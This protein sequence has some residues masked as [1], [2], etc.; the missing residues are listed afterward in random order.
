MLEC[1]FVEIH[2]K[3]LSACA[4]S[5]GITLMMQYFGVIPSQ[6]TIGNIHQVQDKGIQ[7]W[8]FSCKKKLITK[9][10]SWRL[11]EAFDKKKTSSWFIPT[12]RREV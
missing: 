5:L 3:D 7:N 2:F 9:D 12:I 6:S 4:F 10:Y 11:N 8:L 1:D